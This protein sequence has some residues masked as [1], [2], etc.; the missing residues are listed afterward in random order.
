[1][2]YLCDCSGPAIETKKNILDNKNLRAITFASYVCLCTSLIVHPDISI[3]HLF[4]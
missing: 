1:M 2:A 4:H 3:H